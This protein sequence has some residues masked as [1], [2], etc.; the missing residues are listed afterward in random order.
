MSQHH[1][2][3]ISASSTGRAL[4]YLFR[5]TIAEYTPGISNSDADTRLS[6]TMQLISSDD[7][8]P[9]GEREREREREKT[10]A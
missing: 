4:L 6:T 10:M 1:Q 5:L 8:K 2:L 7:I 3:A 9:W